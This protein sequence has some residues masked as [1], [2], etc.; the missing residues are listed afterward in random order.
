MVDKTRIPK[1]MLF[2]TAA[3]AISLATIAR[4]AMADGTLTGS[5]WI[6]KVK[7]R[8]GGADP[9]LALYEWN[10][11]C[12]DN[13]GTYNGKSYRVGSPPNP[14]S[15][16]TFTMPGD[17]YSMYLD[18]P[19]FWGRPKVVTNVTIPSSGSTGLNVQLPTD[20]SCAFGSNSG[21][22]GS[23]PWT[24]W[25]STWYQTFIATGTSVT[26]V[27]FKVAG[28]NAA[29]ML[30]SVHSDNGGNVTTWP[31]VGV[32]RV[33]PGLG[34][35]SDQWVR[36]RSGQV[37]TVPGY[38]YALKLT[39]INGIPNND[40]AIYRRNEDGQGYA[41]GQAYDAGGNAQNFD[42]YEIIFSDND[43]TLVSYCSQVYDSGTLAGW[44]GVWTQQVK[45]IGQGLAGAT[46]YYAGGDTW[47]KMFTFKV[48]SGSVT[49]PQVGP[50]KNV[51][52]AYQALSFGHVAASWNPGEVTLT[53]GTVYYV[54]VSQA[55][56]FNPSKFT[57]GANDYPDGHAFQSYSAQTGVDLHMQV[58]EYA[59]DTPVIRVDPTELKP[60][61]SEGQ[62]PAAGSFVVQ[63]TG[64]GTLEY[65]I[66]DDAAWLSCSPAS[67]TSTGEED[68]VTVTYAATN[69]LPG[70]YQ[71]TISVS[72]SE[73]INSPQTVSVT[74]TVIGSTGCTP[75]NLLNPGFESGSA[76]WSGYCDDSSTI[77]GP[78]G[79]HTGTHWGSVQQGGAQAPRFAWQT[80]ATGSDLVTL[81]GVM[82]DGSHQAHD[83]VVQLIDGDENGTV[84][85]EFRRTNAPGQS[86]GWTSIGI[87]YG[88]PTSG[89]VTVKYGWINN[90]SMW[91]DGTATHVDSL[92]LKTCVGG[93]MSEITLNPTSLSPE[94]D[95]GFSPA[96]DTFTVTNTGDGTLSYTISDNVNWL[97]CSPASGT[98]TGESDTITVTYSTASLAAGSYNATITVSDPNASNNPQTISV[99]LTVNEEQCINGELVNGGFE[100]G[101]SPW[102]T[103]GST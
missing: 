73:A 21:I 2:V 24:S 41:D 38:R 80:V 28:A 44:A 56:G 96:A 70:T 15:F 10:I 76:N 58:V 11:Y 54:E 33:K 19:L 84:M 95:V 63:N 13:G 31:Q 4:P 52:G 36:F 65:T 93:E 6:E 71:A 69:L 66:S 100:S 85:D 3:A 42:L 40:F 25:Q 97:S 89:Y 32:S 34:V 68:T 7:G 17:T 81:T 77:W 101:Q 74:L 37:P 14:Q 90:T 88:M 86:H 72:D 16:Y 49:G 30:V 23:D 35:V 67:G 5:C 50:A 20:Y 26:G 103:F 60:V 43:G 1:L 75:L 57:Q 94:T 83:H 98:S 51:R 45:A 91:S 48:R 64:S 9:Y 87:L 61:A 18:Q 99:S 78:G 55:Q 62:N 59:E 12:M 46:L 39:G 102:V 53:P 79:A 29:D 8:T 82:A 27:N 22:W 92:V 47:D